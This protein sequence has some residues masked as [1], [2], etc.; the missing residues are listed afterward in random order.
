MASMGVDDPARLSPHQLMRRV[1]QHTTS[2]YAELYP[3]L[4]PGEL[5][6]DDPPESWAGDWRHASADTF[7]PV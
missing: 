5:A 2:S 1:D 3:W 6:G 7:A 4:E